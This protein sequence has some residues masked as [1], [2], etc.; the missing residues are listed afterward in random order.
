MAILTNEIVM[1]GIIIV[2]AVGGFILWRRSRKWK[3]T[4]WGPKDQS[5][6]EA[7]YRT[8]SAEG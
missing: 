1:G 2:V 8:P 7:S 6:P 4:P 3:W 5:Q